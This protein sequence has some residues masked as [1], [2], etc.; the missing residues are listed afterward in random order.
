MAKNSNNDII[1]RNLKIALTKSLAEPQGS[2]PA[3]Q[4]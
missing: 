3:P 1:N 2:L 4:L